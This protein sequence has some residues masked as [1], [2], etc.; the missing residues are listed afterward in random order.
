[1]EKKIDIS[2]HFL[3]NFV[4]NEKIEEGNLLSVTNNG[5]Y[6]FDYHLGKCGVVSFKTLERSRNHTFYPHIEEDAE[7]ED[8][9]SVEEDE[10]LI[11]TKYSNGTNEVVKIFNQKCVICYERDSDYA[12]TQCGHQCICEQFCQNKGDIS[13]IKCVVCI[14][15]KKE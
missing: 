4:E 9:V 14:T 11:E 5:F 12:F 15:Y 1:M 6:S 13:I 2:Y 8:D 7:D 10:D 3:T